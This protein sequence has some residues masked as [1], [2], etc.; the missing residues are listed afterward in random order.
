[1]SQSQTETDLDITSEDE[2][3]GF[4][5]VSELAAFLHLSDRHV[6][7]EIAKGEIIV[8]RFGDAVRI[9]LA[10]RTDYIRRKRVAKR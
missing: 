9:S 1:M 4:Q 6:R 5:T 2:F 7:R 3:E 8:H 10:D